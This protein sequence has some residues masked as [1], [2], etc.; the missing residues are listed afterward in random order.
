MKNVTLLLTLF[1]ISA[2]GFTQTKQSI[3]DPN[4]GIDIIVKRNLAN[5]PIKNPKNN[6]LIDQINKLESEYLNLKAKEVQQKFSKQDFS[7]LKTRD[8]VLKV[9][10]KY[11]EKNIE[12]SEYKRIPERLRHKN[13]TMLKKEVK[14]NEKQ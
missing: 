12:R 11:L 4:S 7:N 10:I 8:E 9:Y 14:T 3:D 2:F 6:P 5:Q 1:L 13:R